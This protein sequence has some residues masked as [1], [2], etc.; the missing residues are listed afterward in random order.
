MS[1]P[2]LGAERVVGTERDP[3]GGEHGYPGR[4]HGAEQGHGPEPGRAQGHETR[5][6]LV[7]VQGHETSHGPSAPP[8]GEAVPLPPAFLAWLRDNDVDP[9]VY[10]CSYSI[11][12]FIRVKPG[13][14]C[15]LADLQSVYG[16]SVEAVPWLTGFFSMLPEVRVSVHVCTCCLC[17]L[18]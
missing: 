3:P 4:G 18:G 6:T 5:P 13:T 10:R 12:R 1:L 7:T 8:P 2:Q 16:P 15:T 11:R 9:A 17:V 14:N